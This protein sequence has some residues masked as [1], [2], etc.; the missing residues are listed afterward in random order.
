MCVKDNLAL[1]PL[2]N[3][4]AKTKEKKC[5]VNTSSSN[6]A[7]KCRARGHAAA[8]LG[9]INHMSCEIQNAE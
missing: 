6:L 9:C 7:A 3:H 1:T 5:D 2:S 8:H 4:F